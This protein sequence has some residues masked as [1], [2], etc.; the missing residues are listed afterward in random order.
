MHQISPQMRHQLY[1]YHFGGEHC[2]VQLCAVGFHH[3]EAALKVAF[4]P[5]VVSIAYEILRYNGR[6]SNACTR[7]LSRPGLAFQRLTTKEPEDDM[8]EVAIES[9][10][11]VLP[12]QEKICAEEEQADLK[13]EKTED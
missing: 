9:V 12:R 2:G 10:K 8:I 1:I 4:L 6:H 3:D 7:I 13:E 5:V 11:A